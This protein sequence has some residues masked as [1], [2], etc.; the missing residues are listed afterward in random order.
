MKRFL[1]IP[2]IGVVLT[3]ASLLYVW[4][5]DTWGIE[6]LRY[7]YPLP[8][9]TSFA[10]ALGTHWAISAVGFAVDFLVWL[11]ISVAGIFVLFVL[12][13]RKLLFQRL[14]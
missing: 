9:L 6:V 8:W 3:L 13:S 4:N 11:A 12:N 7:G 2:A 5:L 14:D 10:S 1:L